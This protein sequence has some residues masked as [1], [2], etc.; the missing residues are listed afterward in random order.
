MD[1]WAVLQ[2]FR[3]SAVSSVHKECNKGA[4]L[5]AQLGAKFDKSNVWLEEFPIDIPDAL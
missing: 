5:L 2:T 4:L 3:S 1:V